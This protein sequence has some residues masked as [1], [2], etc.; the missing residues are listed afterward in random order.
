M[1]HWDTPRE[2]KYLGLTP[3]QFNLAFFSVVGAIGL[4]IAIY[5][6]AFGAL[7]GSSGGDGSSSEATVVETDTPTPAGE[8]S[9][10]PIVT[11]EEAANSAVLKL[12]DMPSGWTKDAPDD[13]DLDLEF[14]G[15][16]AFLNED[17][18]PGE[19]ASAESP[20]FEGPEGQGVTSFASVFSDET[21]A[22][23]AVDA[24]NSSFFGICGDQFVAEYQKALLEEFDL[25]G[26]DPSQVEVDV[27][28][29]EVTFPELGEA[30]S[31]HRLSGTMTLEGI[32]VAFAVDFVLAREGRIAGGFVYSAT[33]IVFSDTD[34]VNSFEE[35]VLAETM[36]DKL[37]E[38]N[39]SLA[40]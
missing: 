38:A 5:F 32:P 11:A 21:A 36:A 22:Q 28:L 19:I 1:D 15:E 23:E 12:D 34:I 37:A 6:G 26:Y 3:A 2:E 35:E 24:F 17:E 29:Q 27:S 13:D 14:S 25:R 40:E 30:V 10:A 31:A 20:D 4:G 39:A 7:L 18:F 33:G 16:C 8:A 9:P